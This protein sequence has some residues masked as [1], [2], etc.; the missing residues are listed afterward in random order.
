MQ[1]GSLEEGMAQTIRRIPANAF[2]LARPEGQRRMLE[3]LWEQ[4]RGELTLPSGKN[5]V[6]RAPVDVFGYSQDYAIANDLN[7]VPRP[8]FQS[9]SV[10]G[11]SGIFVGN[12]IGKNAAFPWRQ[13]ACSTRS[14]ISRFLA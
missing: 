4:A 2:A 11:P 10:Y 14:S 5:L 1:L 9:Y 12:S 8:V 7:Y 3:H 13:G 6:G